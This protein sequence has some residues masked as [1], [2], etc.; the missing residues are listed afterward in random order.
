M[1]LMYLQLMLMLLP[2]LRLLPQVTCLKFCA[3]TDPALEVSSSSRQPPALLRRP[4]PPTIHP[5]PLGAA[6]TTHGDTINSASASSYF[7]PVTEKEATSSTL[8]SESQTLVA[9]SAVFLVDE[10]QRL[11][12]E[13][14]RLRAHA[15]TEEVP[16]PY[17]RLRRWWEYIKQVWLPLHPKCTSSCLL[18]WTWVIYLMHHH[19][20]NMIVCHL[21][22]SEVVEWRWTPAGFVLSRD[23][24]RLYGKQTQPSVSGSDVHQLIAV[25]VAH[26]SKLITFYIIK[27]CKKPLLMSTKATIISKM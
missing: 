16:P 25:K 26:T 2:Q 6:N 8:S 14:D 27:N 5:F 13:N 23:L 11:R 21:L 19:Y 18:G 9:G 20:Y 3:V 22:E 24:H 1:A 12:E 4:H 7:L 17:S 15:G 10:V